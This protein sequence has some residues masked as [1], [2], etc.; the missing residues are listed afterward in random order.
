MATPAKGIMLHGY[1]E[2]PPGHDWVLYS[3]PTIPRFR[4]TFF[5]GWDHAFSAETRPDNSA[6]DVVLNDVQV[7]FTAQVGRMLT[8][9]RICS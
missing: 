5:T 1:E 9:T 8:G 6:R 3:S 4:G 7:P 2:P